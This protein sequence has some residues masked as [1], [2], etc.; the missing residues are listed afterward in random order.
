MA[1]DRY[2]QCLLK[3]VDG[4]KQMTCFIPYTL[5]NK[6]LVEDED[7]NQW[8]ISEVY[9]NSIRSESEAN[10]RSADYRHQRKA[11]DI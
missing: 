6:K 10:I 7:K 2:V 5:R 4:N 3:S 8:I 11:S 1:D 9:L